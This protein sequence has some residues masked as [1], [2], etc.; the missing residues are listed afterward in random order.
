MT[1]TVA[2]VWQMATLGGEVLLGMEAVGRKWPGVVVEGTA[3]VLVL[4]RARCP[5]KVDAMEDVEMVP[6]HAPFPFPFPWAL[7][8]EV[9]VLHVVASKFLA[10]SHLIH[11]TQSSSPQ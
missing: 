6:A 3:L 5:S 9:E 7:A 1:Q 2:N 8:C 11:K 4:I 10:L